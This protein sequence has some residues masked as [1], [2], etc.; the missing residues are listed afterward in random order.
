ME[1]HGMEMRRRSR[2][3]IVMLGFGEQRC[4][5]ALRQRWRYGDGDMAM[6]ADTSTSSSISSHVVYV[7]GMLTWFCVS[8]SGFSLSRLQ[9]ASASWEACAGKVHKNVH[10]CLPSRKVTWRQLHRGSHRGQHV[11]GVASNCL[12]FTFQDDVQLALLCPIPIIQS[13][14]TTLAC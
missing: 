14:P 4:R 9:Q 2:R 3:A 10:N 13:I 7:N 1:Q 12:A 8:V 11:G 5:T 6:A